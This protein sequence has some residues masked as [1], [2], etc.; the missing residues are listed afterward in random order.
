MLSALILI[1]PSG[2]ASVKGQL[3]STTDYFTD[4]VD[5][6]VD[7]LIP[8]LS[9]EMEQKLKH[10][11]HWRTQWKVFGFSNMEAEGSPE[12]AYFDVPEA[13]IQYRKSKFETEVG[14][15][16]LNWGVVD[17]SSP[18]DVVNT[19]S[20]FHPTRPIKRGVPMV[21]VQW[22]EESL[23]LEGVYIPKT[24]R[25]QMPSPDS[26]WLPREYLKNISYGQD[27]ISLP[28]FFEYSIL[29]QETLTHALDHNAGARLK[30]HWG[31]WDMQLMHF[32]GAA[33][34]SKIRPTITI[35]ATTSEV[36]A[37]SPVGLTPVTYRVRTSGV[38][39]VWAKESWI[40]RAESV[41]QHTISQDELLQPWSWSNVIGAESAIDIGTTQI[42]GVL[43]YY[44]AENPQS[45]DNLPTSNYRLFDR[46]FL[47]GL[48]LPASDD[49]IWTSSVLY[50]SLTAGFFW[51]VGFDRRYTDTMRWG[52]SWR[53]FSARE[54]GLLKTYDRNDH[55]EFEL[56]YFF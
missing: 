35:D 19:M 12:Q 3:K 4:P 9:V 44:H 39:L 6:R 8:Y 46:T 25:P 20:F 1:S 11:S 13:Y 28:S 32:E 34:Q 7:R 56:T 47:L 31:D 40:V 49:M 53:D 48:R 38:G 37:L 21:H 27:R 24:R 16:T 36:R 54:E 45:A 50:E 41:Y 17:A 2:V 5:E 22:G 29:G 55:I 15:N 23:R 18:S 42:N 26:R 33:P 14:M 10:S 51:T 30:G 43:Q 52:L